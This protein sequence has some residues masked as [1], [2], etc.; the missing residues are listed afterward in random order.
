MWGGIVDKGSVSGCW[1]GSPAGT[2]VL[3][4]RRIGCR[5]VS[6]GNGDP[7]GEPKLWS[8]FPRQRKG[9]FTGRI[10]QVLADELCD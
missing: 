3:L 5:G 6:A 8:F 9:S 2:V 1:F 10:G 4:Y 7:A